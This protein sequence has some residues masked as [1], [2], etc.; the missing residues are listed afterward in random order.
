MPLGI[1][2]AAA[3][4]ATFP[5]DQIAAQIERNLDISA[6]AMRDVPERHR[7]MRAVFEHSWNLLSEEEQ[8]VFRKLT[9]FRGGFEAQAARKVVGASSWVLSAL[10]DKSPVHETS[11]E[12]YEV[13]EL[14]RQCAAEKLR[15]HPG[16]KGEA[17]ERHCEYY[18]AFVGRKAELLKGDRQKTALAEMGVEIENVRAA[19]QQAVA[20]GREE[21]LEQSLIG[22]Y[23]F[24]DIRS[25][26][27]EG[28]AVFSQ[29]AARLQ[30]SPGATDQATGRRAIILGNLLS[31]QGWFSLPPTR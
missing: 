14:L 30:D 2:L 8:R 28:L 21:A 12:R 20:Q 17:Q 15:Q 1:E 18:A 13:H 3:S 26:F 10:V 23:Q 6:T 19:W 25:W 22:L 16:E 24:Y 31:R 7:S 29:A 4:V 9:V 5:C 27:R 11:E